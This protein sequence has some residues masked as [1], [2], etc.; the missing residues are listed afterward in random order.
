MWI[1]LWCVE[2]WFASVTTMVL[3]NEFIVLFTIYTVVVV[4]YVCS[5]Y[6]GGPEKGRLLVALKRAV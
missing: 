6:S 2:E 4:F 5:F 1:I 3:N